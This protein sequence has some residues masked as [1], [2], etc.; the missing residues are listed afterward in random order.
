LL[1]RSGWRLHGVGSAR[2]NAYIRKIVAMQQCGLMRWNLDEVDP[3]VGILEDEMVM[4]FL[5][6]RNGRR[7]R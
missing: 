3:D 6:Y 4:V 1:C 2:R 7:S 5:L